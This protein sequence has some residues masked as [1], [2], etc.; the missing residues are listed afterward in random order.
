MIHWQHPASPEDYLQEFGRAGRDGRRSV[1]VLLTDEAPEGPAV[2]LLDF[3]AQLTVDNAKVP[4]DQRH[5]LLAR[6]KRQSRQ[7]QHLAFA[8]TCFRDALLSYFGEA[9]FTRA[10]A[11]RIVDWIF[12]GRQPRVEVGFAAM[13]AMRSAAL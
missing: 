13:S 6:K 5:A 11:L 1:A 12:A 2:K 8:E 10:L 4:P 7:M 3:M 9:R